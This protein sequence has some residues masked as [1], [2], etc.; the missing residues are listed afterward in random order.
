[1]T[2]LAMVFSFIGVMAFCQLMRG[3]GETVVQAVNKIFPAVAALS[4]VASGYL[5]KRAPNGKANF[6]KNWKFVEIRQW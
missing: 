3:A 5:P 2:L 4:V 1:S 6:N